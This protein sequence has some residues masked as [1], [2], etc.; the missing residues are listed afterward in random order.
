VSAPT[1][2]SVADF[3]AKVAGHLARAQRKIPHA[4]PQ[5]VFDKAITPMMDELQQ[6]DDYLFGFGYEERQQEDT[7]RAVVHKRDAKRRQ[8]DLEER[9]M[10]IDERVQRAMA[11]L[12]VDRSAFLLLPMEADM[13]ADAFVRFL[14]AMPAAAFAE[15]RCIPPDFPASRDETVAGLIALMRER[16]AKA[17]AP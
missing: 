5:D 4:V 14:D 13:L 7:E 9:A 16:K 6:L 10:L 12:G 2:V 17:V 8:P 15:G 3:R 11:S 1:Q